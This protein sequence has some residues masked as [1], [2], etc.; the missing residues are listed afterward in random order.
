MST[1]LTLSQSISGYTLHAQA[2]RL[3]PHTLAD[4]AN[5]FRK[6][7]KHAGDLPVSSLTPPILRAFLTSQP[8]SAKT[9]LNYHVG[10]SALFNWLLLENLITSNPMRQVQRPKPNHRAIDPLTET[11][12]RALYATAS[13]TYQPDRTRALICLLL[14]TGLRASELCDSRILDLDTKNRRLKVTGKGSKERILPLS[15]RTTSTLWKYLTTRPDDP[16]DRP[17][18]TTY[19]N[20]PLTRDRLLKFLISLGNRAGVPNVHPH[21][22]RHTFAILYLRNGGDPFTLQLLLGHS[23]MATVRI[24]LTL[25]Q[26]DLDARHRLASPVDRLNL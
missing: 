18:I 5:T 20:Q 14:D 6:L 22:F 23:D 26:S 9:C 2:R 1:N 11:D 19:Q 7:L 15:P 24:Y 16:P 25:A 8:V 3:S 21:R 12:L 13:K 4:Y 10:L 17:L